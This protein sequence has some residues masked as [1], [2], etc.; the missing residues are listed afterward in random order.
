MASILYMVSFGFAKWYSQMG[1]VFILMILAVLIP[2]TLSDIVV[3]MMFA[4]NKKPINK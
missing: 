1:L 2:C 3:P 4:K